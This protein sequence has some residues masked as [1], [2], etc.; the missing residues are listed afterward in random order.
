MHATETYNPIPRPKL[1]WLDV[2]YRIQ[3]VG[4]GILAM[5]LTAIVAKQIA[6]VFGG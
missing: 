1:T 6:M 5:A 4:Y 3:L 2:F